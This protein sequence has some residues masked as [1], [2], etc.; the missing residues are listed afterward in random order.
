MTRIPVRLSR[1]FALFSAA[2]VAPE[3]TST[4]YS[5]ILLF[6]LLKVYIVGWIIH[7]AKKARHKNQSKS[8]TKD[9]KE[10]G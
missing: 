2:N 10:L 7:F 9:K 5:T 1:I 3:G 6:Y 8:A 4:V